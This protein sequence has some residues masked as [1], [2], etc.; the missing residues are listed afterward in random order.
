M[1][2]DAPGHFATDEYERELKAFIGTAIS[3]LMWKKDPVLGLIRSEERSRVSHT[4]LTMRS[5]QVVE[6]APIT[7]EMTFA[8]ETQDVIAGRTDTLLVAVDNMADQGLAQLMP[9]VFGD[10]QRV[11]EASGNVVGGAGQ[12]PSHD[13]I[14]KTL[15]ALELDFDEHGNLIYPTMICSPTILAKFA[16]LPP[17]TPEQEQALAALIERKREE[18]YAR[19]RHRQLSSDS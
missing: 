14:I 2:N 18:F 1:N 12:G 19:R 11:C 4:R 15:A 3:Q 7:T 16:A 5:G 17:P 10:L 8:V 6:N 13:L 9:R